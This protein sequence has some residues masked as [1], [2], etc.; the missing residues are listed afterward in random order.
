[1]E[2]AMEAPTGPSIG[3]SERTYGKI[4]W[5]VIPYLFVCYLFNYLDRVNVGFAKLQMLDDLRMSETVYGFGAGIFFV[6]YLAC[7]LPSN[8]V[9]QR[10]GARRWTAIIMVVWGALSASLMF[11]TGPLSFYCLRFLTG[12]AEAGFF[13]GIVL[14]LTRWFPAVRH[15]RVM[16]LFMAAIPVS[17]VFGGLISG[18]ILG[19]FSHG[20]GGLAGWQWLFLLEGVPTIVL[21]VG[22]WLFLSD[23]IDD[24]R[25]LDPDERAALRT[26]LAEDDRAKNTDAADTLAAVVRNPAI[27]R[28]G[29]I[30]FCAQ[31]GVYAIN[32]WLPSIIKGSGMT[33]ATIIGALSAIPYLAATIFMIATGRSADRHDERRWHLAVPLGIGAAGLILASAFVGNTAL[34]LFG[35]TLATMGA[36][37]SLPLFWPLANRSLTAG[38]AAGGVALINSTGQVAGFV[39]PYLVGW[40]K[41]AT[42]STQIA[43]Y[44]LAGAMLVG[45]LLVFRTPGLSRAAR[46]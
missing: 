9:L 32:F 44:M 22:A 17:G 12:A 33:D 20:Q 23:G 16:T 37:T 10:V 1:L 15:G 4:A 34:A 35:M 45:V 24:A 7:G 38:A 36:L 40:I 18:W 27:W 28:L 31:S 26:A 41:D 5:R 25:W 46:R 43:L 21:G 11:A 3:A 29:I 39:S 2:L 13:P 30:Y 19:H 8:L 14:Y 6:G 42:G